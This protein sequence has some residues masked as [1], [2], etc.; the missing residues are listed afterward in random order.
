MYWFISCTSSDHR[1][2]PVH[3]L[4]GDAAAEERLSPARLSGEE[5]IALLLAE[6]LDVVPAEVHGLPHVLVGRLAAF[7]LHLGVVEVFQGK[8][9]E[10]LAV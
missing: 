3:E 2:P 1:E 8:M 10:V 9:L 7:R 4:L 5:D 6:A